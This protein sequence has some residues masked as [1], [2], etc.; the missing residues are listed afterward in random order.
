MIRRNTKIINDLD[1]LRLSI[2]LECLMKY[3]IVVRIDILYTH[4]TTY[5]D[6]WELA[7]YQLSKHQNAKQVFVRKEGMFIAFELKG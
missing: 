4:E 6:S 1:L 2:Y 3:V 5:Y 7:F